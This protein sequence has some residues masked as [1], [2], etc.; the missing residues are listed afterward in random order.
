MKMVGYDLKKCGE[1][2]AS[3]FLRACSALRANAT[4]SIWLEMNR[5]GGAGARGEGVGE[6]KQNN[7]PNI[8]EKTRV[9]LCLG[10]RGGLEGD[11]YKIPFITENRKMN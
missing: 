11:V 1:G 6:M 9:G 10:I 4:W 8:S 7:P 3:S 2:P 5:R